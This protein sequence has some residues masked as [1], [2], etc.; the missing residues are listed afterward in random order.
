MSIA[1]VA[2]GILLIA[3]S[4][5]LGNGIAER[6][7][8]RRKFYEEFLRFIDFMQSEINF[9]NS[10][11]DDIIK[12]YTEKSKSEFGKA[13]QK[14][15]KGEYAEI[16]SEYL[17]G[18]KKLDRDA[19]KSYSEAFGIRIEKAVTSAETAEKRNATLIKK[20]LPLTGVAAF[21]LLL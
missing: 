19:Q 5:I 15:G 4:V 13:L 16:L 8:E 14:G 9:Y 11:I 1:N 2:A 20:I 3:A 17:N 18:M 6:Y 7:T 10:E 12:K 21:I